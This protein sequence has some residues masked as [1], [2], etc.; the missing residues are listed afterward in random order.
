MDSLIPLLILKCLVCF[1]VGGKQC[2]EQ[3]KE[4]QRRL[5]IFHLVMLYPSVSQLYGHVLL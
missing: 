2:I 4:D 1:L 3:E 5:V